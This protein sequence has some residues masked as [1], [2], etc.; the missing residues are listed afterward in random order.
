MRDPAVAPGVI[1]V[2]LR[3]RP[4]CPR[5]QRPMPSAGSSPGLVSGGT[6]AVPDMSLASVPPAGA[7]PEG[8]ATLPATTGEVNGNANL[9]TAVSG[10]QR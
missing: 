9:G 10:D 4:R 2:P 3:H 5:C 6:T 8:T 7:A 1:Q